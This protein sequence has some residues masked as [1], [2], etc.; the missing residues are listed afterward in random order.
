MHDSMMP[1]WVKSFSSYGSINGIAINPE[2]NWIIA[3]TG[4]SLSDIVLILDAYG[5]LKGAYTYN[6]APEYEYMSR[7]IL[8]GFDTKTS[9]YSALI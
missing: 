3:H 6:N 2:T 5:N 9:T 4:A 7:N 1:S 8:L